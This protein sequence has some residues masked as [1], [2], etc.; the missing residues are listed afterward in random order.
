MKEIKKTIRQAVCFAAAAVFFLTAAFCVYAANKGIILEKFTKDEA[1][2]VYLKNPGEFKNLACQIGTKECRDVTVDSSGKDIPIHTYLLMDNSQ[3][4]G[5]QYRGKIAEIFGNIVGNGGKNETFTLATFGHQ[6]NVLSE[7]TDDY[8]KLKSQIDSLE[9]IQQ[10]T[11][12]NDVLYD[13]LDRIADTDSTNYVRIVIVSDGVDTRKIGIT[14]EELEKKLE[15]E[16]IPIY[17]IGCKNAQNEEYLKNMFALSRESYGTSVLLDD[18]A[19]TMDIATDLSG[20]DGIPK[21]ITVK[22]P[23]ELCDGSE[24]SLQLTLDNGLTA[25]ADIKMPFSKEVKSSAA[26]TTAA[27][28]TAAETEAPEEEE[29]KGFPLLKYLPFILIALA[30]LAAAA[31]IVLLRSRSGKKQKFVSVNN[32]PPA[33]DEDKTEVIGPSRDQDSDTMALLDDG[34]SLMLILQ[35]LRSPEKH[36]EYPLRG[37]AVIGRNRAE[38]QIVLDDKTV[39]RK[40]CEVYPEGSSFKIRDL[41]SH[42]GTFVDNVRVTGTADIYSGC[43]IKL[44]R[45]ELQVTIQ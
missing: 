3:A 35:D 23:A 44:G 12:L 20:P 14:S 16:N 29:E 17:T 9:Y 39:G 36:Y 13:L 1:T 19:N 22:L 8:A 30:V 37:M 10:E 26:A 45:T 15:Q 5:E 42:N 27:P 31:V 38:C 33:R 11:F 21:K 18:I 7:D 2:V 28:T 43:I 25:S 41:Q 34:H 4:I 32:L 40:H 24:K 6:I